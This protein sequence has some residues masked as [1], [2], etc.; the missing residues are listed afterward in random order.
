MDFHN[1]YLFV[2]VVERGSYISAAKELGMPTSTLSRRIQQLEEELGYQL[3]YRS[4]RKLSMTEAGALF[5]RRCH[6]LYEELDD[7]TQGLEGELTLPQGTLKITAPVSLANELLNPWFFEF[8]EQYPS[9]NLDLFLT[10]QNIDLKGEGID[11]AFRIGDIKIP[12]WV[13]R[14]LFTSRF[15]LCASPKL[16]K[17]YGHPESIDQLMDYPLILSRRIPHWT[18]TD[19]TGMTH[20]ISGTPRLLFDELRGAVEATEAGIGVANL[21]DYV[22]G[23]ALTIG[24]LVSLLPEYEPVSRE[25]RMVYPHFQYLPA[26]VRLFIDFM[27]QKAQEE[28]HAIAAR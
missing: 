9:I 3:L 5:Y 1:L 7:A 12:D 21:P 23:E 10:N 14:H 6:P 18:F 24:R 15:S 16:I 2:K 25:V 22:V 19:K 4:A 26:K 20:E 13:S 17:Q 28:N 27:L 8:M 11:I